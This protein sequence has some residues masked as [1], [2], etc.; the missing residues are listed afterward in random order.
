MAGSILEGAPFLPDI[1][2]EGLVEAVGYGV[3]RFVAE[4]TAGFADVRLRV[5]HIAGSCRSVSRNDSC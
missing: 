4:E 3:G 1:P 5:G 2:R